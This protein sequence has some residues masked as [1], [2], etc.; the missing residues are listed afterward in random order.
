MC[1]AED[2]QAAEAAKRTR[3]GQADLRGSQGVSSPNLVLA[4]LGG[5][6]WSSRV[7][8][9]PADRLERTWFG[10]DG[11]TVR[12][13]GKTLKSIDGKTARPAIRQ[14]RQNHRRQDGQAVTAIRSVL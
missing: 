2:S 12:P 10:R 9:A 14:Y 7:S 1:Q 11:N 3:G 8:L 6:W 5:L 13:C 4:W